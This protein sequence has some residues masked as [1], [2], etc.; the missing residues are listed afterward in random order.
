MLHDA[1][2]YKLSEETRKLASR[3]VKGEFGIE[4]KSRFCAFID[5]ADFRSKSPAVRYGIAVQA[6]VEQDDI[7][8]IEG[9]LLAGSASFDKTRMAA[10]PV[11]LRGC[12]EK[13]LLCRGFDHLTPNFEKVLKLKRK[14]A[15]S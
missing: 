2:E 3:A 14:T 1:S 12:D 15:L 6:V 9:E 4:M 10:M 5:D 13:E 8:I 7:R 11:A